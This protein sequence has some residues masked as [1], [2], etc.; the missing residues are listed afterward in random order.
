HVIENELTGT[1][2]A[3][4]P[5]PVS[6]YD[7]TKALGKVLHRPTIFPLPEFVLKLLFG[8][9]STVL[10][11]SKEVYPKALL[12]SGFRFKYPNIENALTH[13]LG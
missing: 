8:E 1:F 5:E 2:N 13:L 10:T 12:A 9:G 11:G 4:A 3:T 7:F 6:N